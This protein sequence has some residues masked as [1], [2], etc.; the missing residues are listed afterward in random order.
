MNPTIESIKQFVSYHSYFVK[1]SLDENDLTFTTRRNCWG[2]NYAEADLDEAYKLKEL[3]LSKYWNTIK[4]EI[5][6]CDEW[7]SVYI[8]IL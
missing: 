4:V 8:D 2:G 5:D 3:L 6:T 1:R 7:V